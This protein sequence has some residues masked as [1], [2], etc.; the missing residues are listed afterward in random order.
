MDNI[1]YLL[2]LFLETMLVTHIL[3]E[4]HIG[5]K[6]TKFNEIELLKMIINENLLSYSNQKE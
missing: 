4:S 1:F 3:T 2:F 5:Y 6:I